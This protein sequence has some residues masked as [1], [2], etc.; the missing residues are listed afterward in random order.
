[1][2]YKIFIIEMIFKFILGSI[3][4]ITI[5][6]YFI[7]QII[8]NFKKKRQKP[9]IRQNDVQIRLK[10]ANRQYYKQFK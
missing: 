7:K 5:Y 10:K 2:G 6:S 1:M 8:A 4:L 9:S 3:I